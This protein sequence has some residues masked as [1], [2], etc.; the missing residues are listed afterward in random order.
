MFA[1]SETSP[2]QASA[3]KYPLELNPLKKKMEKKLSKI[4]NHKF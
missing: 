1:N 3:A 4:K 2:K